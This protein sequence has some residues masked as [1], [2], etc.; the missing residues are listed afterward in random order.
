LICKICNRE[1]AGEGFCSLHLKAYEN[2]V[3]SYEQWRKALKIPW[4]GYLSQI[5]ENS[6]AGDWAKE[7]SKYLIENGE[8]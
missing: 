1:V 2:L 7:V 5:A 4:K 6:S 8:T 3:S